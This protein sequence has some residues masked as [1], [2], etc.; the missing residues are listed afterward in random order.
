[1]IVGAI[2]TILVMFVQPGLLTPK[3]SDT[4]KNAAPAVLFVGYD[5]ILAG[6]ADG[7]NAD[8]TAEPIDLTGQYLIEVEPEDRV[9][10]GG[11]NDG[12]QASG[13]RLGASLFWGLGGLRQAGPNCTSN[14][15]NTRTRASILCGRSFT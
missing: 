8:Y 2:S 6:G 15:A 5:P 1:M 14:C 9:G 3:V 4:I 11:G 7:Q 10:E 13:M 12:E